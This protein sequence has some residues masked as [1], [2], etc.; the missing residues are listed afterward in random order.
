MRSFRAGFLLWFV[1]LAATPV[2]A[3]T[4]THPPP[5]TYGTSATS[6]LPVPAVAFFPEDSSCAYTTEDPPVFRFGYT[7]N[8]TRFFAPV[9]LP[10]GAKIVSLQWNFFDG[11]ANEFGTAALLTAPVLGDSSTSHPLAGA[12]PGD[13]VTGGTICTGLVFAGGK[14]SITAD[15]TPDNITVDNVNTT[16]TLRLSIPS[17]N[18][19][20]STGQILVGYVLQVSPAPATATFNDVPTSDPAFRYIEAFVAAGVTAGCQANPPLYCPDANVTR[21]QM[22]VFFAKALGLQ[23]Q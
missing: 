2:A 20:V 21:R 1:L 18:G 23:F 14:S 7:C 4:A 13:C 22:A 10:D 5:R 6:Y 9:V 12:G 17:Q 8:P 15:L 19:G 16:Y 11:Y 3:Q